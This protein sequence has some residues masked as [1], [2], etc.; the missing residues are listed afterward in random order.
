MH[1]GRA[2]DDKDVICDGRIGKKNAVKLSNAYAP[3]ALW[4]L[5]R[6]KGRGC[7]RRAATRDKKPEQVA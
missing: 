6:K 1:D 7:G 5:L 3:Y 2:T 4:K